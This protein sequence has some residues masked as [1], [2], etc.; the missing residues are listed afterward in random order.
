MILSNTPTLDLHGET[1]DIS[2]ILVKEFI[3]DCFKIGEETAVIIHGIGSG[4]IRKTVQEVLQKNKKVEKFYLD[5]T[6][7]GQ[8]IIK[9]KTNI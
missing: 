1:K 4:I 7:P 6:N 9:I 2:M 5:F 8:T 3:D